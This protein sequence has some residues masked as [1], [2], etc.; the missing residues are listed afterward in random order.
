MFIHEAVKKAMD[1][2]GYITRTGWP[3]E[4]RLRPTDDIGGIL[5]LSKNYESPRPRWQP[6][7]EDLMAKDWIVTREGLT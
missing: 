3:W 6:Q 4:V 5:V 7:A 1:I 2:N